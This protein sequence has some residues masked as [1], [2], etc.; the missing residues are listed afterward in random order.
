MPYLEYEDQQRALGPGVLTIGSGTESIWRIQNRDLEP[1]HAI[2]TLE[3]DGRALVARGGKRAAMFINDAEID[4]GKG[5]LAPGDSLRLGTATF[6]YRKTVNASEGEGYLR[7]TRRGRSYKLGAVTQIGREPRCAVLIQEAEVSR[8]HA[9]IIR[10]RGRFTLKPVG[11]TYLLH[12]GE[13]V[14][15]AADLCEGDEISV[16]RTILRF[17]AEPGPYRAA[18]PEEGHIRM[19]KR[20]ARMQTV[21]MGAIEVRERLERRDRRKMGAI[22][23]VLIAVGMLVASLLTG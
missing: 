18:E 6:T 19:D 1:L 13:R 12:N 20:A 23:A 8:V 2:I 5:M 22:V 11:Q 21:Y 16:G 15:D 17:S 4:N 10:D 14:Q 7:D 9:E 3:R